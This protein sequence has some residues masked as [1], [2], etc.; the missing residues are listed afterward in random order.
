MNL[1]ILTPFFVAGE[2]HSVRIHANL[3]RFYDHCHE[4]FGISPHVLTCQP[5][6]GLW[7]KE[8]LINHAVANLPGGYDTIAWIDGDLHF[9]NDNW[10]ED[11]EAALRTD[12]VVQLFSDVI[13]LNAN[14]SIQDGHR[15]C[16]A[17]GINQPGGPDP[18]CP[19]FAWAARRELW[20]HGGLYDGDII[21]GGDSAAFHGWVNRPWSRHRTPDQDRHYHAWLNQ[22]TGYVQ[23]RVGF[24]PGLIVHSWHGEIKNRQYVDRYRILSEEQFNPYQHIRIAHEGHWEWTAAAPERLRSRMRDY[25]TSRRD[26]G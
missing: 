9:H 25:F 2:N 22:S 7:Q 23:G 8:R 12:R 11:L 19:G 10:P 15:R 6:T 5:G 4:R 17:S 24:I 20:D 1:A 21:G 13:R 26:D 16:S 18:Q 3:D 14:G